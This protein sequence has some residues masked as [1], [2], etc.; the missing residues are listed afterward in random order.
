MAKTTP[1]QRFARIF[2]IWVD[3]NAPEGERAAAERKLD[4]WLKQH[5]TTRADIGSILAQ[6]AADDAAAQPPLPPSDPRDTA[7]ADPLGAE[8][9]PLDLIHALAQDYLA[10]DSH[11]YVALALWA[12]H[13]HVYDRFE[14]TPRLMLTSP[15]RGCGKTTAVKVLG[16]VVGR[17]EPVISIT[18]GA[19]YDT[20]H[21]LRPRC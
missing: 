8:I 19:L 2:A 3:K 20:I 18:Q 14:H 17:P 1:A 16:R 9:T 6:A 10:L 21:R 4:A 13:A 11:E 12:V 7:P 15:V 5:G